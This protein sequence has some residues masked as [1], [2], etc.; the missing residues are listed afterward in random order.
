MV[1]ISAFVKLLVFLVR[2]RAHA[3]THPTI[4]GNPVLGIIK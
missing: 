3:F 4:T 2:R 1:K